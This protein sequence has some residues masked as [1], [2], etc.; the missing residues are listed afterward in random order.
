MILFRVSSMK[1][2][3]SHRIQFV[4]CDRIL[5]S[6]LWYDTRYWPANFA[7]SFNVA[8]VAAIIHRPVPDVTVGVKYLLIARNIWYLCL[9]FGLNPG[10][11]PCSLNAFYLCCAR[12]CWSRT[13][14]TLRWG[15][16]AG[17]GMISQSPTSWRH[18]WRVPTHMYTICTLYRHIIYTCIA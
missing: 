7:A 13:S 1:E 5:K 15:E 3:V 2:T 16:C 18:A 8:Q 11:V 12:L 17:N 4:L 9:M 14:R 6:V 10:V